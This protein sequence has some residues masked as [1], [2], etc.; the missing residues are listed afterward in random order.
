M[1][2]DEECGNIPDAINCG[3]PTGRIDAWHRAIEELTSDA[4][5]LLDQSL[6][7]GMNKP[8]ALFSRASISLSIG[9]PAELQRAVEL[10]DTVIQQNSH[11]LKLKAQGV[12]VEDTIA[13]ENAYNQRA[14][15]LMGLGRNL[16]AKEDF[17]LAVEINPKLWEGYINLA[18]LY[19]EINDASTAKRVLETGAEVYKSTVAGPLHLTFL[20]QLGYAEE[21]VGKYPQALMY[22]QRGLEVVEECRTG[23]WTYDASHENKLKNNA[24]KMERMLV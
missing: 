21:L 18:S 17:L 15:A 12:P 14:L 5:T 8:I 4:A 10:L 19:F 2:S 16:E 6:T 7:L 9:T 13:M 23:G 24:R 20:I 1:H 22:Y 3:H 11:L